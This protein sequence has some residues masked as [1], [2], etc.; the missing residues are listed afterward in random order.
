[1]RDHSYIFSNLDPSAGSLEG[2]VS[3]EEVNNTQSV[4]FNNCSGRGRCVD[5]AC[6]CDVG[7][8]GDDCSF[9]ELYCSNTSTVSTLSVVS[10]GL[11]AARKQLSR[12]ILLPVACAVFFL[13]HAVHGYSIINRDN[14]NSVP[15]D[16]TVS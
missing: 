12:H 16:F 10:R 8:D 4:C 7:Y 2:T 13:P 14:I 1:M 3:P 5:Y 6:E 11:R 9:C 15:L